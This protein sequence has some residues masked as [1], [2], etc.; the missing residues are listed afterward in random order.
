MGEVGGQD[1]RR[2]GEEWGGSLD[3]DSRDLLKGVAGVLMRVAG[4][5]L[6]GGDWN[7][8]PEQL[9]ATGWLR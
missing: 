4:T 9:T 7:C 3:R 5:W 6:I 2:Y 1:G 8:T